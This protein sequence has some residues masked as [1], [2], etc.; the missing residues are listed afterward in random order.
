V[1]PQESAQTHL[2]ALQAIAESFSQADYRE[3]LR[4]A[5]DDNELF[6]A[7]IEPI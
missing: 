7:A 2:E 3:R 4:A 1:V 6:D 5:A